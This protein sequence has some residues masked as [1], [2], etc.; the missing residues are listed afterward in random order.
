MILEKALAKHHGNYRHLK[1]GNPLMGV[2]TLHG[3]P[4]EHRYHDHEDDGEVEKLWKML[5]EHDAND[6]I[7]LAGTGG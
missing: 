4:W 3:G 2:R 6:E 1:S 7:M 5:S